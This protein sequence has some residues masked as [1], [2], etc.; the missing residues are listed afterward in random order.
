MLWWALAGQ[1]RWGDIVDAANTL[2]APLSQRLRE[3]QGL[4]YIKLGEM[5]RAVTHYE[6]WF[7]EHPDLAEVGRRLAGLYAHAGRAADAEALLNRLAEED[8]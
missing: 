6:A 7:A 2:V 4:A 5:A 8:H 3:L 1:N